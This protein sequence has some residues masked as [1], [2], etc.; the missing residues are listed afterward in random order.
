VSDYRAVTDGFL[1]ACSAVVG[2]TRHVDWSFSYVLGRKPDLANI[3]AVVSFASAHAFTHVRLVND[4][5]DLE[6]SAGVDQIRSEFVNCPGESLVIYQGRKTF[7]RGTPRCLISLLKPVVGA[8]GHM[9]PC[10]GAQYA[11]DTP[12]RDYKGEVDMGHWRDFPRLFTEQRY[13]DGSVCSCCY[14]G[15][16][17]TLLESMTAHL[18]HREFV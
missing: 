6:Q 10:C 7:T 9:F 18:S 13:F 2:R 16:Y 3:R 14:Y 11:T 8:D 15:S 1:A 12:I 5:L 4:L 17:N